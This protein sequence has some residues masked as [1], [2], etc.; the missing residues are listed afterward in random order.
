VPKTPKAPK[1]VKEEETVQEGEAGE[2]VEKGKR[3]FKCRYDGHPELFGRLS[4][5]KPKQAANKAFTSILKH[6]KSVGIVY[7]PEKLIYFSIKESTRK[8]KTG[9]YNYVGYRKSLDTPLLVKIK[10]KE[11]DANGVEVDVVKEVP[12]KNKNIVKK[13]PKNHPPA[14]PAVLPEALPAAVPQAV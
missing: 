4:G 7:D 14:L 8:S 1:V 12:Y 5:K 2:E 13:V 11:K 10:A 3:Y 9:E 6:M